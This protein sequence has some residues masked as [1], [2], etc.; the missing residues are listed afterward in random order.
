MGENAIKE[1]YSVITIVTPTYNR[2]KTLPR[3]YNSLCIQ[4]VKCFE[5]V[6]VDDG[7][8]D[9]TLELIE[10]YQ[11]KSPFPIKVVAKDNGGKHTALNEGVKS[12]CGDWIFIVDSDDAL[13]KDSIEVIYKEINLITDDFVGL[14]FRKASLD[15]AILG[16][17]IELLN[18][19]E[20]LTPTQAGHLYI[21]DL[22]YVFR[23]NAMLKQLF[24]IIN[25]EKFV[26]ELYIWN[27][28]SDLGL[29]KFFGHKC[30]YLCE[31]L[32][33]GYS[34]N[35]LQNLKKNPKGFAL[36]YSAQIYRES[37]LVPKCK[38]FIR[39]FQCQWYILRS[40]L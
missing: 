7:S 37:K 27:K 20:I 30:I 18:P 6:V 31:Y 12:A 39:W 3:L 29:I 11:L 2:A 34:H 33:D 14:C 26:P 23:K 19:E 15:G 22:A 1:T 25:G 10:S 32:E 9:S 21:S 40:K 38:S 8:K 4:T 36:H 16:K 5:W 35:F 28:I 13:P 24:P 17:P